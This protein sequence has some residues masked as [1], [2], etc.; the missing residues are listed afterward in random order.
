MTKR[1]PSYHTYLQLDRL[2]DCQLPPSFETGSDLDTRELLHHEELLFIVMHQT[3]ELWFKLVLADLEAARDLIGRPGER[4]RQVP[5]D[6]I[7]RACSYLHRGAEL[8]RHLTGQFT[9]IETMAPLHFLSFRDQLIPSSGFQSWQFREL[10]V[11]AGL[12]EAERINFEGKPYFAHMEPERRAGIDRRMKEM[13]LREAVVDWLARTP[14]E[15]AFPGFVDTFLEAHARYIDEQAAHQA[16][17]PNLA[18]EQTAAIRGRFERAKDEARAFFREGDETLRRAHAAFVFISTYRR[19]PLLRWPYALLERALE[20]E[21][22]FRL[23]RFRH[24]RMVERMIGLRVGS[25]GSTGVEYLDATAGKY[26]IFGDLLHSVSYLIEGARL[27][28]EPPRPDILRF[29]YQG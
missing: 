3:I 6:D 15:E 9:I 17:N 13:S 21:E 11:L 12:P 2:L 22:H 20:F 29:R 24:A 23:F 14:V 18:P 16:R 28:V 4:D 1:S 10:E 5:E 26:R 19:E 7:P 8:F 25:G 27:P